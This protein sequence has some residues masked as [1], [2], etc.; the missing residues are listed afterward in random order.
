MAQFFATYPGLRAEAEAQ[1]RGSGPLRTALGRLLRPQE[2]TDRLN[3]PIQATGADGLKLGLAQLWAGRPRGVPAWPVAVVHDEVLREAPREM[4][5]VVQ[6]WAVAALTA[7]MQTLLR[8]VP[9][10]AEARICRDWS[11]TP[12]EDD[13]HEEGA[14]GDAG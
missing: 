2:P 5:G 11:G 3:Y 10:V 6:A 9:V 1:V 12:V 13:G 14:D 7:G 4:A 8:R